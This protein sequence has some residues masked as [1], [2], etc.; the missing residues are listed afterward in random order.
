MSEW[1]IPKLPSGN[2]VCLNIQHVVLDCVQAFVQPDKHEILVFP[3]AMGFFS[4]SLSIK[5][6]S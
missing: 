1:T 3:V 4:I 2:S 5:T 6:S